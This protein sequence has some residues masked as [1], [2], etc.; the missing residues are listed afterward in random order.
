MLLLL[1]LL[2]LIWL[3]I[4]GVGVRRIQHHTLTSRL[5]RRHRRRSSGN[6]D[7]GSSAGCKDGVESMGMCEMAEMAEMGGCL[8][9]CCLVLVFPVSFLFFSPIPSLVILFSRFSCGLH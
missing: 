5:R 7:G 9:C 2:L 3:L 6:S 1:V 4:Q 8:C